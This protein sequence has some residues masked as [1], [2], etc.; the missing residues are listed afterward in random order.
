[1]QISIII[2]AAGSSSRMGS[3]KQ[4]LK[5]DDEFLLRRVVKEAVGA[6]IGAVVVVVGSDEASV[7][8][9]LA[10]LPVMVVVNK[11][12]QQGMGASIK[13][14]V[15]YVLNARPA[16]EAILIMV[17]D[18]PHVDAL[19][20][21]KIAKESIHPDKPIVA[22]FYNETPGVPA[23][24]SA[25]YFAALLALPDAQGAKKVIQENLMHTRLVDFPEGAIDL[26][27]PDDFDRFVNRRG[28]H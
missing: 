4:L 12:W 7:R 9:S 14:G 21:Q 18:Q 16:T 22:S 20:L 23:I 17:C 25:P 1:M 3:A 27:T 28:E 26:D 6:D 15:Q 19:Y 8:D 24:F 2:L 5:I 10:A 11:N 13:S